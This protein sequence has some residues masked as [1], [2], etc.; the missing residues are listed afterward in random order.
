MRVS[1]QV[2]RG[3][4]V[5]QCIEFEAASLEDAHRQAMHLGYAV[6]S[7]P[8]GAV[9]QWIGARAESAGSRTDVTVFAEQ[10]RDLL[11]A[12]L[13]VIEAL[14][15]LQRSAVPRQRAPLDALIQRLRAGERLSQA[16]AAQAQYPSLLVA[17]VRASELTSDLPQ[18]LTRYVE[19]EQRL[20]ELRH[21]IA[22]VAIYPL[23]LTGVGAAVL[24]F[25][26]LYV[27]P[28]FARVFEGMGEALPWSA[29]AMVW[30]SQ[31]LQAHGG[32]LTLG[33]A[34]IGVGLVLLLASR[35]RRGRALHRLLQWAP[36]RLRL[37]TYFLARWYRTTG[38]LVHGGI[39]LP[40]ALSLSSTVLPAGLQAGGL[41]TERALRDG[42]SPAQAHARAGMSTPV[43]EQLLQAGEGTGD[44]GAVLTRIAQFHEAEVARGLERGMR[45]LEPVV[46][47]LIGIGVGAVVVLMYLPIF[48]LASA[49]Q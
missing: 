4:D 5:P 32:W 46:M 11:T 9:A 26:L 1:L 13:S 34:A 23:L 19:H 12:G 7:R 17:L 39:P 21:R 18:A 3:R 37:R 44:V 25:L 10:L 16:L 38:M 40:E 49:I 47:V 45:S 20:A 48:E 8:P 30:W 14:V 33:A 42:F 28:R 15:T 36:L 35:E 2:V 22:S 24:L 41:A 31:W 29:R 43:A 27:M 6:L